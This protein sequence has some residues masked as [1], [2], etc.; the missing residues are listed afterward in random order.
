MILDGWWNHPKSRERKPIGTYQYLWPTGI[1]N[2]LYTIS[3]EN[4]IKFKL[5]I[6]KYQI[7]YTGK[8]TNLWETVDEMSQI[9]QSVVDLNYNNECFICGWTKK[10]FVLYFLLKVHF[11]NLFH[12]WCCGFSISWIIGKLSE[13]LYQL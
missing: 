4:C 6:L 8:W 2:L 5:Q 12:D 9:C 10:L 11:A 13:N 3:E 1:K 7:T